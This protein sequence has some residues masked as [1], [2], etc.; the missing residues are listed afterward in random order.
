MGSLEPYTAALF[1]K[2]TNCFDSF[3]LKMV[4]FFY[5][6]LLLLFS[7]YTIR[8]IYNNVSGF[9][10]LLL[11]VFSPSFF[12]IWSLKARGGYI[13]TL[14]FGTIIFL[15]AHHV[16]HSSKFFHSLIK[17]DDKISINR[18]LLPV[19]YMTQ[20]VTASILFIQVVS[21]GINVNFYGI[22]FSNSGFIKP[23]FI[24]VFSLFVQFAIK[25]EDIKIF[26]IM[27]HKHW[28]FV[29][30][31]GFFC[32]LAW[33]T[34]QLIIFFILPTAVAVALALRNY[35]TSP[36]YQTL[37]SIIFTLSFVVG[38]LPMW[39]YNLFIDGLSD[40]FGG[41]AHPELWTNQFISFFSTGFFRL[42]GIF[43]ENSSNILQI[44]I[45]CMVVLVY[46]LSFIHMSIIIFNKY[47]KIQKYHVN[48]IGFNEILFLSIIFSPIIFSVSSFG[49]FVSEPRY[50]LPFF[51]SFQFLICLFIEK[52]YR[53]NKGIGIFFMIIIII[54]S[55]LQYRNINFENMQPWVKARK[56]P[57]SLES[58]YDFLND[59]NISHI[60]TN[61][62]L[63][64]RITFETHENIIATV[65][66][67][68]YDRYPLYTEKVD[69]DENVA[70]VIMNSVSSGFE[71]NLQNKNVVDYCK[72]ELD[73]LVVYYNLPVRI[74]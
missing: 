22:K 71:S 18:I 34:N 9:I 50:L 69:K 15:A 28:L 64:Y 49:G 11:I 30:L 21:G 10:F 36:R 56:V 65:F 26:N 72:K 53:I 16:I 2:I 41:V 73:P 45:D 5:S 29:I 60:Y 48:Q 40:S 20:I 38:S 19:I 42:L 25:R 1:F 17:N 6:I 31:L 4:P 55:I 12:L 51:L 74:N 27:I 39:Y 58:L 13:E 62:W 46:F 59:K 37:F 8:K 43:S 47:N 33:W 63:A 7:Y 32:G 57:L 3:S 52:T 70:Y 35:F 44:I 61:Y 14:L 54:S 24:Y 66:K 68:E 67:N 23:L